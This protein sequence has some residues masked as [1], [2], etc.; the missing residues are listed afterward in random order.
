VSPCSDFTTVNT[1][2]LLLFLGDKWNSRR[3]ILTLEFHFKILEEFVQVFN[4]NCGFLA[5]NLGTQIE[6]PFV[7]INAHITK[8]TWDIICGKYQI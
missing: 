3:Q 1:C 4:V 8:C 6:E 2:I 7:D 5:K